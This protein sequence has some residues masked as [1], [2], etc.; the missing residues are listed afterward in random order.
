M[1][2]VVL[3]RRQ[4]HYIHRLCPSDLPLCILSII[5]VCSSG[6]K[7]FDLSAWLADA[8]GQLLCRCWAHD[9][10]GKSIVPPAVFYN[11]H[12]RPTTTNCF[13]ISILLYHL[14]ILWGWSS[15]FIFNNPHHSTILSHI[16]GGWFH[17]DFESVNLI[18]GG[19][20]RNTFPSSTHQTNRKYSISLHLNTLHWQS[21]SMVLP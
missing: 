8:H 10:D 19:L 16:G 5:V 15:R 18:Y 6:L 3:D 13:L 17:F 7:G 11:M 1:P 21:P 2:L 9:L 4:S 12:W 20:L 14:T